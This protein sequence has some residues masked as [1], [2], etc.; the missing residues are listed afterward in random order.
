MFGIRNVASDRTTG[1]GIEGVVNGLI[2]NT[3]QA[4]SLAY[5]APRQAKEGDFESAKAMMAQWRIAL[6]QAHLV[7]PK[8]SE[9][10]HAA[11]NSK[12]DLVLV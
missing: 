3:G 5:G 11:V 4:R 2:I 1:V 12:V 7:Q 6:N 8:L 9:G 10:D